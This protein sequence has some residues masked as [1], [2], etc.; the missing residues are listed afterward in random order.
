[1]ADLYKR[2]IEII[3]QNQSS[4]GAFIASPNFASYHYCWYRDGAFIAYAMDRVGKHESAVRFHA[5]A[6]DTVNLHEAVVK[7][8]VEKVAT[9]K[10]LSEED[11]LHTRYTLEGGIGEEQWPNFQLDGFGTWL[12]ALNEHLK[13]NSLEISEAQQRAVRLLA[14]Y[15]INLWKVPCYD[16]WEE[17]PDHI[18]PYTLAAIY[19]GLQAIEGLLKVDYRSI[20][21]EICEYILEHNFE[22]HHFV[23][24]NGASE[25]DASLIGLALPYNVFQ[26]N[27]ERIQSTIERIDA[28]LRV[29]GGGVHRYPTDTYYGGGEWV[30]L[31]GWLGWYYA[32]VGEKDKAVDLLTWMEAQANGKGD[33]PEQVP[34]TLNDSSFYIPWLQRWGE[35]AQPLLWSHANY[36]ILSNALSL[37]K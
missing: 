3:E 5:W 14:K 16:C 17:F 23:K 27:D 8:A 26:L 7:M 20:R 19:A 36:L 11:V 31:A 33:L 6:T 21:R 2:S 34:Q 32:E 10:V 37:G 29:G 35:I 9:G 28:T 24:F 25:V 4:S 12:W 1:M 22:D 18:H 30:V 15:L 13:I